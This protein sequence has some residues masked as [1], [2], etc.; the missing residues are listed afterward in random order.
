MVHGSARF[1]GLI[2]K[3][4]LAQEALEGRHLHFESR[5]P[6]QGTAC[7]MVLLLQVV[8]EVFTEI[9][10]TEPKV[11]AI[12]AGLECGI[13]GE[14]CNGMDM[15]SFGP[16]IKGA[17]SPDEAVSLQLAELL[18]IAKD[19]F[20]SRCSADALMLAHSLNGVQLAHLF[21][22]YAHQ[23]MPGFSIFIRHL[24]IR[25]PDTSLFVTV[26]GQ[27]VYEHFRA[28][29]FSHVHG[30]QHKDGSS[31]HVLPVDAPSS[32]LVPQMLLDQA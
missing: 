15:V 12:H 19:K 17:H 20:H 23:K 16:T 24:R 25:R 28:G 8:K 5:R 2:S 32:W 18:P 27:L 13:I 7:D 9:L 31:W 30:Q 4:G 29:P 14:R 22:G 26:P 6:F 1:L 3:A 10:G 21:L 11:G